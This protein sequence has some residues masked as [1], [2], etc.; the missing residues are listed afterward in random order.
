LA[1]RTYSL[2]RRFC[3]PSG[4]CFFFP[5]SV[6]VRRFYSFTST[7]F[8]YFSLPSVL[9]FFSTASMHCH[10]C[11]HPPLPIFRFLRVF[12]TSRPVISWCRP[13][14]LFVF[15]SP[16]IRNFSSARRF[17]LCLGSLFLWFPS[18]ITTFFARPSFTFE[19][20]CINLGSPCPPF[21]E[22]NG[23]PLFVAGCT[24]FFFRC[25]HLSQGVSAKSL[26]KVKL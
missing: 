23:S 13:N 17:L 26:S 14:R 16:S 18:D 20:G 25:S 5:A 6:P 4:D 2:L 10:S 11:L 9:F 21:V 8:F 12:P 1:A 19:V 7:F 3:C 24:P 15:S 22:S